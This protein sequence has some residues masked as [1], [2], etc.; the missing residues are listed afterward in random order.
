MHHLFDIPYL[1]STYGYVGIFVIV[2]LESGI[3]FALPGDS[4]LFTAGILAAGGLLDVTILVPLIFVAT[5]FGGLF[6]Y[7][8]GVNIEKLRRYIVFKKILKDEYI[9][10][11]HVFFSKHG[12][13]AIIFSRFVPVVRTFAPIVAG[14]ARM[15]KKAFVRYSVISSLLWS[16]LVTF[17]GFFLGQSFPW[18]T[19][20]MPL[21]IGI[22]VV[23]SLIPPLVEVFRKRK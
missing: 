8:V 5:L 17:L 23:L 13:S 19:D 14:V 12:R 2:F 10:K 4:L 1:V 9:R 15:D 22:V 3:F 11:A 16:V 18:L 21:L 6:G 20:Y 7:W